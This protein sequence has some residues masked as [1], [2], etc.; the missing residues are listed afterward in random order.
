[1]TN[2]NDNRYKSKIETD[3]TWN[4]AFYGSPTKGG[5]FVIILVIIFLLW[6]VNNT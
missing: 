5:C 2:R 3:D 1:M 6:L 4:R